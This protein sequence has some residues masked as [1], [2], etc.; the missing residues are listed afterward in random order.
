MKISGTDPHM[1]PYSYIHLI[2]DKGTK[3]IKWRKDSL[4][5]KCGW[6]TWTSAYRKLKLDPFALYK[7]QLKV[8]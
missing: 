6:E 8:D 3:S 2:F 1:N 7:F 5:K 4:F